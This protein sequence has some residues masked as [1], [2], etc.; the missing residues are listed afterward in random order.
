MGIRRS[1][2]GSNA[3]RT[4]ALVAACLAVANCA[5]NGKFSRVD[6]KCGVPSSPRVVAWGDRVPRG[7]GPS[8]GG[9]P[10]AGAGRVYARGED[11]ASRAGGLASWYG[12]VFP[13]RLTAN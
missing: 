1:E 4:A 8:R 5:Q 12:D 13:G 11:A 9:N 3:V 6:P 10:Y 7:G 2:L